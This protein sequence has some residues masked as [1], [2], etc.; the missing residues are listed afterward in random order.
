MLR[1]EAAK[2]MDREIFEGEIIPRLN[3]KFSGMRP[4]VFLSKPHI[5]SEFY[6]PGG[7]LEALIGKLLDHLLKISDAA[8]H[9]RIAVS[10]KRRMSDLEQFFCIFPR[11]WFRL[12]VECQAAS[13]IEDGA[14]TI[15]ENQGYHCPEWIGV[16]GSESQLGAFYSGTQETPA[17]ILFIQNQGAR[18]K[19]ELLI[20]VMESVTSLAH[21]I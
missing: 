3:A 2:E 21:A 20:P 13:S 9:V 1:Q 4:A 5:L 15:L 18:R 14:K 19:C 10:E 6:W 12:S 7:N 17:I 16:E 8:R 11:Y